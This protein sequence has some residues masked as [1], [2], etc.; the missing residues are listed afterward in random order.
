MNNKKAYIFDLDGVIVDTAK[1]HF[2]AWHKL[3]SKIGIE[4]TKKENEQL[5]GVSRIKSL[6]KILSWGNKTI[7]DEEF[8]KLMAEKNQDYLQHVH[9]MTKDDILP[10]VQDFLEVLKFK[11]Q[12]IALGSASKN[13]KTIL[14][15]VGLTHIFDAIVDGNEV[16]KGKP[17]PEVFLKAADWLNCSPENSIVFEDSIAGI[18][19][20]NTA[21]MLSIGIG[22]KDTLKEADYCFKNFKE[23]DYQFFEDIKIK[24]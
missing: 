7:S 17:D 19:A 24:K 8:Q 22:D 13:S 12:P 16:T 18:K 23:F 9:Q 21:K 5:K 14:K 1:F 4:F 3:A 6:Q 20:A 15:A 2:L 11:D 10:G